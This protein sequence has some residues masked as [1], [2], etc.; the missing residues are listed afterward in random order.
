M[1]VPEILQTLDP[2]WD[3]II[4]SPFSQQDV[5]ELESSAG[6]SLPE[7]L[8]VFLLTVGLFQD[9]THWG[10]SSIQVY[11]S[12]RE[13]IAAR[14]F[15]CDL[16][17]A[18]NHDL[19]PFGDD[20]AGNMYCLSTGG[21]DWI[22]LVDHETGKIKKGKVFADWLQAVVTKVL[23]GIGKRIP[24]EH[25]VWAVQ[26][27]FRDTPY[28]GLKALLAGAGGFREVDTDWVIEKS[29]E[30]AVKSSHRRIE[31]NGQSLELNRQE[32]AGWSCPMFSFNMR[33]SLANGRESSQIRILNRL[34][35]AKC[36]GY[37]LVDYGPLDSRKLK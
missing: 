10:A 36:R 27:S 26:F 37:R 23:R 33:E 28:D 24:N 5:D 8:K 11:E 18:K 30:G 1:N 6:T 7:P 21:D 3:R 34:F 29:A 9:L 19:F 35:K 22:Y 31:L 13:L 14:Q 25:K 32:Y 17:P 2:Y 15:L 4:R 12:V 20:G 16:L